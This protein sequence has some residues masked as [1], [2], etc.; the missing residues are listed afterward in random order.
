[1]RELF[2]VVFHPAD[3]SENDPPAKKIKDEQACGCH[4]LKIITTFSRRSNDD[5]INVLYYN[6]ES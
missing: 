6:I 4:S 5:E 3:Q 2:D 1:L